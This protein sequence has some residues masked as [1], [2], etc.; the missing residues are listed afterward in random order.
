MDV[1][2]VQKTGNM[3]YVYLPTR[4]CKKHSI[5]SSSKV[6]VSTDS[7]G[8]LLVLPEFS[9][10]EEKHLKLSLDEED[11]DL[12]IKLI[13]ACYINPITSFKINL[14]EKIDFSK[15]LT[16]KKFG[17]LDL[18]EMDGNKISYESTLSVTKPGALLKTMVRKI[19]NL[20]LVKIDGGSKDLMHKYEEE[21]DKS[22]FLIDKAVISS[23]SFSEILDT[24]LKH[25]DLF[26]LSIISQN[27]EGLADHIL[28]LD[29]SKRSFLKK[30]VDIVE[31]L[32]V[33][34]EDMN[35]DDKS[36]K[37][38]YK[39]ALEFTKLVSGI[40][41]VKVKDLQTYDKKRIRKDLMNISEVLI[42]WSITKEIGK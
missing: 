22:H 5:N 19:K 27:L 8:G 14:G 13:V 2:N 32:Q 7:E 17:G 37:F 39:L 6:G 10:K 23:L 3:Y 33:I 25:V 4:W 9:E 20:L 11:K 38:N 41:P 36:K 34:L 28:L 35:S 21:I 30:I 26:Y 18:I 15:L 31:Q 1:R 24:P 29:E 12:I 40:E 16:E 42:D